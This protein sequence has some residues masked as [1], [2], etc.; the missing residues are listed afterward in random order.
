MADKKDEQK[1]EGQKEKN[2]F[3]GSPEEN[4]PDLEAEKTQNKQE[5]QFEKEAKTGKGDTADQ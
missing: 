5:E 1:N 4:Y 3:T 2:A